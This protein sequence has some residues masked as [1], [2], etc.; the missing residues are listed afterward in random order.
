MVKSR[1]LRP[2][3]PDYRWWIGGLPMVPVVR[4]PV[5]PAPTAVLAM[6]RPGFFDETG[7]ARRGFRR[8][9]RRRCLGKTGFRSG[10]REIRPADCNAGE[11]ACRESQSASQS[12][13]RVLPMAIGSQAEIAQ[14][15]PW[16]NK[17]AVERAPTTYTASR[18]SLQTVQGLAITAQ[19]HRSS[20]RQSHDQFWQSK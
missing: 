10:L 15:P 11:R 2:A 3:L 19:S 9:H 5:I 8:Q 17:V 20:P 6:M 7:G 4:A 13:G 1:S 14:C 18:G 12:H 16:W